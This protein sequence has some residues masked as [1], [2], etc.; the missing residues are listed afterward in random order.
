MKTQ[1]TF[2]K[3]SAVYWIIYDKN[4][5]EPFFAIKCVGILDSIFIFVTDTVL[6]ELLLNLFSALKSVTVYSIEQ[7]FFLSNELVYGA[8]SLND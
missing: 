3:Q 6:S 8:S 1:L 7:Q 2:R 4:T 5:K